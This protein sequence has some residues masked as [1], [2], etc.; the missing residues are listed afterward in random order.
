MR[1][2]GTLL[3]PVVLVVVT[4][5]VAIPL[6][7]AQTPQPLPPSV[8][9]N[10]P[11]QPIQP[12][13]AT[14]TVA[15]SAPLARFQDLR[16][17]PAETVAAIYT[18][19]SGADWLWRMN[20]PNGRFF[21]GINPTLKIAISE[22]P[23]L[24]QACAALALARAARFTGDEKLATR[25]SQAVLVLL[26]LTKPDPQDPTC[27]MPIAP[28]DK[29]NR[30]GFAA[31]LALATFEFPDAKMHAEGESLCRFL[32]KRLRNDGSVHYVDGET[33]VPTKVDPEGI[34]IYPGLAL[35]AIAVSNRITPQA[36]KPEAVS[37][38]AT[39]YR[40]YFQSQPSPMLAATMLP[41][42]AECAGAGKDDPVKLTAFEMADWLCEK[43]YTAANSAQRSWMGGFQAGTGEPTA[44]SA[45][46]AMGLCHAVKLTRS[47]G[48]LTR[49]ATYRRAAVDALQFARGLQFTD[50]S[51]DH[52]EKSFR[53][54]FL[55]GGVHVSP[56]DGTTRIDATAAVVSAQ[57]AF[58][59]SGG[60]MRAE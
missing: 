35:E 40:A 12:A 16:K 51:A 9:G 48:D 6:L 46:C 14:T 18:M 52:F 38:S 25:A 45:V 8:T 32:R 59:S 28:S 5:A 21:P 10:P 37:K 41:A 1:R 17:F 54:R 33:D 60:E 3:F 20:Q 57:L 49:Y 19:R 39:Y 47:T 43:Q 34:A 2:V 30:V 4:T 24:R 44:D 29:C 7:L 11:A 22:D 15:A 31:M 27:R 58:L 23:D 42:F 36:W 50:E 56:T 13:S 53:T 26:T 55:L